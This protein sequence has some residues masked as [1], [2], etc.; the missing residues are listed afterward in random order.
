M[1]MHFFFNTI[2][3]SPVRIDVYYVNLLQYLSVKIFFSNYQISQIRFLRRMSF[4]LFEIN[5]RRNGKSIECW[6]HQHEQKLLFCKYLLLSDVT[7]VIKFMVWF[8]QY[9]LAFDMRMSFQHS[10]FH[11]AVVDIISTF[12]MLQY[13]LFLCFLF[14][15]GSID[16]FK[17]KKKSRSVGYDKIVM[18]QCANLVKIV[19]DIVWLSTK[20]VNPK[21]SSQKYHL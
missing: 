13:W 7:E 8:R 21:I 14:L 19:R 20:V 12:I 10:F 9:L 4:V 15:L 6:S 1:K 3:F 16:N 18:R 5:I 11:F 2:Q 17:L